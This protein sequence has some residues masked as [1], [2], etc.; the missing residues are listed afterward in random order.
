MGKVT[1]EGTRSLITVPN[2]INP[3]LFPA[4]THLV[5]TLSFV[6][7][8]VEQ[9]IKKEA[10]PGVGEIAELSR[11]PF[12]S[13]GS[14]PHWSPVV[15]LIA[16]HQG[17]KLHDHERGIILGW[18]NSKDRPSSPKHCPDNDTSLELCSS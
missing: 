8:E 15:G 5:Q 11:L 7:C 14:G 9:R 4:Q 3:E 10:S 1:I 2:I 12:S 16:K 13:L 17:L 6:T 18:G